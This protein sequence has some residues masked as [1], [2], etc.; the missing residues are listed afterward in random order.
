VGAIAISALS[1][2]TVI[3]KDLVTFG[4]VLL[5]KPAVEPTFTIYL[6]LNIAIIVNVVDS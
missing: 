5:D 6:N 3:T 4:E 2:V 1:A